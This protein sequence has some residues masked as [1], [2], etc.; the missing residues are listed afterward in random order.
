MSKDWETIEYQLSVF[1][2]IPYKSQA[3]ML[4]ETIK[5]GSEGSSSFQELVDMYKTQDIEAMYMTMQDDQMGGGDFED[6]LLTNRNRNWIPIIDQMVRE[7]PSFI[8]VG[9]G[10]LGG[11]H[12]VVRLLQEAGFTMTPIAPK[13]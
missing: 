12:G 13:E 8:A 4:V 6:V 9:A 5:M 1:D 11:P 2:S 7:K 10:H 3:E